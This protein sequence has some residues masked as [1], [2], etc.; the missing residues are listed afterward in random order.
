MKKYKIT[1]WDNEI[2]ELEIV[3]E[4]ACFVWVKNDSTIG[5]CREKKESRCGIICET[6]QQA[7]DLLLVR[8]TNEVEAAKRRL[9]EA[10]EDLQEVEKMNPSPAGQ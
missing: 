3:K 4:T 9:V 2:E 7:Y 8:K 6:W 5:Y 1:R 10:E